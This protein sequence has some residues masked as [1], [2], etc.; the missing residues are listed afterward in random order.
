MYVVH[1][2]NSSDIE[3]LKKVRPFRSKINMSTTTPRNN[4]LLR[5]CSFDED[6][7]QY[8]PGNKELFIRLMSCDNKV[9]LN[10]FSYVLKQGKSLPY[11]AV[12]E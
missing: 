6:L 5:V 10:R 11:Y 3:C 4:R 2:V 1:S 8:V 9:E 12:G 7:F